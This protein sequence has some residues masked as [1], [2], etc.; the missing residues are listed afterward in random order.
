MEEKK[1][2]WAS[3]PLLATVFLIMFVV[4]ALKERD[5]KPKAIDQTK[6]VV[7]N[8]EVKYEPKYVPPLETT[9]TPAPVTTIK[10][11]KEKKQYL[12]IWEVTPVYRGQDIG[13]EIVG[14]L[15]PG[16]Q[17]PIN[18]KGRLLFEKSMWVPV[19]VDGI[20]GYIFVG[21]K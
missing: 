4:D 1:N 15:R 20:E 21:R 17:V 6:Y 18:N 16:T 3:L 5:P 7:V 8:R 11:P 2:W 10:K 13:H 14:F 9:S 12:Q 19:L